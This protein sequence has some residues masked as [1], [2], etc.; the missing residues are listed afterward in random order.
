M[1]VLGADKMAV[2]YRLGTVGGF[3]TCL[4][5]ICKVMIAKPSTAAFMIDIIKGSVIAIN[6]VS[7]PASTGVPSESVKKTK[8]IGALIGLSVN[9]MYTR[10]AKEF[11]TIATR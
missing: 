3:C 7:H 4:G 8:N 1:A 2:S 9:L 5:V 6:D 11:V 10:Y